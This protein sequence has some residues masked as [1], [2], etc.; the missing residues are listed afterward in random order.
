V[1]LP[2]SYLNG[3]APRD[4]QPLY[5]SLWKGCV[6]AWNPGLGPSGLTLRDWSGFKNN[7][8]L[9]NGPTWGL[10]GGKQAITFDG[11]DDYVAAGTMATNLSGSFMFSAWINPTSSGIG[12]VVVSEV[13]SYS[14]YWAFLGPDGTD[15]QFALYDGTNNPRATF[16]Y[17]T[18]WKHLAG[19]RNT[20]ADTVELWVNGKLVSSIADTTTSVPVYGALNIGRQITVNRRFTGSISDVAI[21]TGEGL[22]PIAKLLAT[23]PGI[24]YEMAPRR[25]SSSAVAVTSYSTFRP[26]VLRGSR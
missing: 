26:S 6:R 23:R 12:A 9:T 5:P 25:R 13:S 15:F 24:A 14:N 4:G 19:V 18:G 8:T 10:V 16:A 22:S 17:S 2:A 11:A 20:S 21:H 7:G 1:I 3:F